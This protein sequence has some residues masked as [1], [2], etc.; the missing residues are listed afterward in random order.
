MRKTITQQNIYSKNN[1][2]G[3]K[4]QFVNPSEIEEKNYQ[5]K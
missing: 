5:S 2:D 3:M 4:S 1:N